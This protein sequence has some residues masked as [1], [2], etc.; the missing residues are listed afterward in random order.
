MAEDVNISPDEKYILVRS[1]GSPSLIELEESL[2]KIAELR[3]KHNIN[4]I[5]VD[6]R[7]RSSQP[8]VTEIFQGGKLLVEKLGTRA[9]VAILVSE[10]TSEHKLFENVTVNRGSTVAFFRNEDSA[11]AWLDTGAD[12]EPVR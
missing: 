9:R 4:K 12:D 8:M 11:C 2:S 5:L 1:S 3:Q 6:S 10:I 7:S